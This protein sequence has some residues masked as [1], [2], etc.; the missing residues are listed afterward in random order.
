MPDN[1]VDLSNIWGKTPASTPVVST[2]TAATP[3]LSSIWGSSRE[4]APVVSQQPTSTT[5]LGAIWGT[6]KPRPN[7]GQPPV[8]EPIGP[9]Q[10]VYQD[11]TQP[12]YK[13]AWDWANTPI[14]ESVFGLP[15]DRPG[16]G[17]FERG[18]EHIASGLTSPLS[19]ALTA[20]T[21]GGGGLLESAGAT[22]L[23]E[24][25]QFTAEEIAQIAKGTEIASQ[26]MKEMP[27]AEPAI[28]AALEA[29]GHDPALLNRAR[30]IFAPL[31]K[32]TELGTEET[33]K[34]LSEV[35][36]TPA[37]R[38]ALSKGEL[39]EEERNTLA[40][41]HGGFTDDEINALGKAGQT[42]KSAEENFK[43]VEDAVK[44]AGVD[45]SL[46]MRGQDAL[47]ANKLSAED[48]IGGDLVTRGA[49]QILRKA[50]PT[51]PVAVAARAAKT[52]QEI[53][54]AGFPTSSCSR[55]P[56]CPPG[57]LTL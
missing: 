20:A 9:A 37:Q 16:A 39:S 3:D 31:L 4:A 47:A 14:T 15:E 43:P 44:A 23:K 38:T 24:T 33:Q 40:G 42:A 45:P 52:A 32:D 54:S 46:W 34:A 56:R 17:G 18:V 25:G 27:S 29:G 57:S 13:R 50:A 2:P 35:G 11:E 28:K 5:D 8:T 6:A 22:A 21:F 10:H 53:M 48:L 41:E 30:D 19:L 12:W 51:L 49:F 1:P 36:L 26:V 55:L 7:N